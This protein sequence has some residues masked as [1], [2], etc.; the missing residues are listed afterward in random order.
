ME[1]Y[2]TIT[3]SFTDWQYF[4]KRKKQ[5]KRE[6][7]VKFCMVSPQRIVAESGGAAPL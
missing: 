7:V 6:C 4:D 2:A 5:E 1:Q 3:Q